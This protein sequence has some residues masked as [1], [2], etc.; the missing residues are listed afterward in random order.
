[1]AKVQKNNKIKLISA[2]N[3][4]SDSETHTH[5]RTKRTKRTENN[6]KEHENKKYNKYKLASAWHCFYCTY[7]FPYI[8]Y[9][10]VLLVFGGIKEVPGRGGLGARF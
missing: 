9:R 6:N 7:C 4:P 8:I 10:V 3:Q 5:A 2:L 1:M